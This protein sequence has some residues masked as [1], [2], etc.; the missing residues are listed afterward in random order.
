MTQFVTT[1]DLN[2]ITLF[3]QDWGSL[4][5]LR[6]AAENQHRFA[7]FSPWFPSGKIIQQGTITELSADA[8]AAYD[9]PF[10]GSKYKTAARAFPALVPTT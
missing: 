10:P 2:G 7:R 1:L 9:A 6:V 3:C 5:G 4:I 8:V